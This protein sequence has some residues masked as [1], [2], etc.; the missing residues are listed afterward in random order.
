MNRQPVATD[1]R[2][3]PAGAS[4]EAGTP[5]RTDGT[6]SRRL[7]IAALVRIDSGGAYANLVLPGLLA[8]SGLEGPDRRLA[9]ELVYGATRMRRA[10]D[11]LVDAF[12]LRP[13]DGP[14]RAALRVGAHQLAVLG[15]PAHAAVSATV[16][17]TRGPARRLVNAV[18]RRLAAQLAAG[19]P[20]WPDEATRLSYPDW[21][22]GRLCADLGDERAL[23]ALEAMNRVAPADVRPDGYVQDRASQWVADLVGAGPGHR[24]ADLCAAPGGK[25]TAL[26]GTGAVVIAGDLRPARARAV[27]EN[28][29]RLGLADLHTVVAD[30]RRPPLRP[31]SCD[32]VLVD[33]PCS[34]LG[35]LRRRPDARW[36][37]EPD[38][39]SRLAH[40]QR[41]LLDGAALGLR[42]GGTLVYSVCTLTDEETLGVDR[43]LA[44]AH[45][46]LEAVAPPGPPWRAHGRGAR[47]LPQDEGTDGMYTLILRRTV[48]D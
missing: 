40:L 2:D 47:L 1:D 37:I 7:A 12:L 14:T 16:G 23:A 33:A 5:G 35:A 24:V 4:D 15:T 19:P 31:G 46:E 11:H 38:A 32:R 30:G 9:T 29:R 41:Q 26:A 27:A 3:D 34:G 17:A 21:L 22:V 48:Q 13:V 39:I 43:W 18:L 25:A 36:R 6:P 28:G 45:P 8:R 42:P 44:D 20:H 10:L